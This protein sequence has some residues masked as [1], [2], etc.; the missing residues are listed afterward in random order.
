MPEKH[1]KKHGKKWKLSTFRKFTSTLLILQ[2]TCDLCQGDQVKIPGKK[3]K[4]KVL[5]HVTKDYVVIMSFKKIY[6]LA[7][8]KSTIIKPFFKSKICRNVSFCLSFSFY[9]IV[10]KFRDYSELYIVIGLSEN[11]ITQH[12]FIAFCII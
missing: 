2:Q 11:M 8:A 9:F 3:R 10:W 4:E 5:C 1:E 6:Q 12:R 7:I